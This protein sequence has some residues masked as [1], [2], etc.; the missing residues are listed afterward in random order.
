MNITVVE[1][2]ALGSVDAGLAALLDVRIAGVARRTA[3]GRAF[4]WLGRHAG[5]A[6]IWETVSVAGPD[7]SAEG[8]WKIDACDVRRRPRASVPM[9]DRLGLR[10]RPDG[11]TAASRPNRVTAHVW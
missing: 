4:R 9:A 3:S 6:Q 1:G 8:W 7:G 5:G 2:D 11:T 10:A